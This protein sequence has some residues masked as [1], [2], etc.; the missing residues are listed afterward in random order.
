MDAMHSTTDFGIGGPW[1]AEYTLASIGAGVMLFDMTGHVVQW[2]RPAAELLGIREQ[3]L[4]GCALHGDVIGTV[5]QDGSRITPADDPVRDVLDSGRTSSGLTIGVP[6]DG[7][8]ATRWLTLNLLPVFGV[9]QAPRAVLA[10]LVDVSDKIEARSTETAWHMALRSIIRAGIVA[11]VLLDPAGEILEWNEHVLG[12]A[13]RNEVDLISSKFSDVCDVD[14]DWLWSQLEGADAGSV[15]GLTWV[16]HRLGREIAVH[17]RFTKLDHPTYGRTVMAQ[18]MAPTDGLVN[19]E[20]SPTGTGSTMFQRSVVPMLMVTD[21]GT[22]VDAN[23]SAASLLQRPRTSLFGEP[24]ICH[25]GGLASDDFQ[26]ALS[27]ANVR[28][29][30]V[31]AG[32]C[33]DRR[34]GGGG[35]MSVVISATISDSPASLLLVQL[36]GGLRFATDGVRPHD[37]SAA[38]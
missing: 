19:E 33:V 21:S 6:A 12:L 22:I 4:A 37:G 31:A 25:L 10:S 3:D 13:D 11:I 15:E 32:R 26:R 14:V 1:L 29:D 2:D 24:A 16:T 17:G 27:E 30:P 9:D 18:L 36:I 23:A 28:P 34:T 35:E 5:W 8:L 38:A 7:E 20:P